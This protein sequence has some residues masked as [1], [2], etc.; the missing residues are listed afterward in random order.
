MRVLM[1]PNPARLVAFRGHGREDAPPRAAFAGRRREV[2]GQHVKHGLRIASEHTFPTPGS[3]ALRGDT[4]A[5][6]LRRAR[7][8]FREHD[9]DDIVP[10]H[11][12][13]PRALD[14]I[15]HI[16]GRRNQD[17]E[18]IHGGIAL[19]PKGGDEVSHELA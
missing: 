18:S 3:Q 7:R 13:I 19:P 6:L 5:L 15:D 1:R 10:V 4:V 17:T 9:V 2:L 12:G 14:S 11:C 16:V 8:R